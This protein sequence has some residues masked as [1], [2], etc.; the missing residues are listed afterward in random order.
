MRR[1]GKNRKRRAERQEDAQDRKELYN[2]LTIAEKIEKLD[3]ELGKKIG[4]KKQRAKLTMQ[5]EKIKPVK[6]KKEKKDAKK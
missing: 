1:I 2:E 3:K 5:T 6:L 4:A